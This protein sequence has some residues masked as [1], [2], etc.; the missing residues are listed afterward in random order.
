MNESQNKI[1][2]EM[3]TKILREHNE[4]LLLLQ[5]FPNDLDHLKDWKKKKEN[6]LEKIVKK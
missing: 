5:S 2:P 4:M 3:I 6:L 1:S